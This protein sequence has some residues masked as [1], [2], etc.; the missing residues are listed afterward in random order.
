MEIQN[1]VNR[2]QQDL[3]SLPKVKQTLQQLHEECQKLQD[4]QD[5]N[6]DF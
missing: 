4:A 2:N 6:I 3:E 1:K 5:D